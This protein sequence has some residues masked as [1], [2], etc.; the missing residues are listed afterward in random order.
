MPTHEQEE[1]ML[2]RLPRWVATDHFVIRAQFSGRPS[3]DQI[4]L[5]M[6]SLLAERFKLAT[7]FESK[8]VPALALVLDKAGKLGP[9]IRLH[10]E[11]P[12]CGAPLTIPTD[13]ASSSVPPGAF[14]P[15]CG[16]VQAIDGPKHTILLGARNITLDHLAGYLPDFEDLGRTVVDQTGLSG[17]FDFSLSWVHE[18]AG[19]P[20]GVAD[21]SDSQGPSFFEAL[22]DQLGLKLKPTRA[23]VQTLVI[24]HVEPPSPN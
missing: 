12:P 20:A 5:M 1:A 2:A 13:R 8:E 22:K 9:R 16:R 17:T 3:K 15:S 21:P 14:L 11:G 23:D 7:H 10:S 19:S 4:R 18:Q 24:D 6:Q